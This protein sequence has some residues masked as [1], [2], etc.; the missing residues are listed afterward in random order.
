MSASVKAA[1]RPDIV[2]LEVARLTPLK[3][4]T[5][6]MRKDR[7]YKQI[8]ASLTR[9]LMEPIVVFQGRGEYLVLDGHKRLDILKTRYHRGA[10]FARQRRRVVHLQ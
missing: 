4:I 6:A 9:C 10:V 8:A 7:K 3:E 2:I 5:A 1:F